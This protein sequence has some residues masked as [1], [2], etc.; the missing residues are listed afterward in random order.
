MTPWWADEC[1]CQHCDRP[2]V[3]LGWKNGF[4]VSLCEEHV[5]MYGSAYDRVE[6]KPKEVCDAER[7]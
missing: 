4:Q 2:R 3:A 5:G 7:P 6:R 1:L